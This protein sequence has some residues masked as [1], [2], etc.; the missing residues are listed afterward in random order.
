MK[1]VGT[2]LIGSF[3]L[4]NLMMLFIEPASFEYGIHHGKYSIFSSREFYLVYHIWG[5]VLAAVAVYTMWK[6]I[7]RLFMISLF[8]LCLLMFYPYLTQNPAVKSQVTH[9]QDS[10]INLYP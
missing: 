4:F 8:L 3:A 2:L 7:S 9:S 6:E 5:I 10:T 1:I